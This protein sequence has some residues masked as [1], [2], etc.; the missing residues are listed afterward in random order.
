MTYYEC[1]E[2]CEHDINFPPH[3]GPCPAGCNDEDDL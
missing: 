3:T 2:C 1:C